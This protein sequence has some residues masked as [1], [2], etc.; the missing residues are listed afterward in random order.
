VKW[1]KRKAPH[2]L[3][4]LSGQRRFPFPLVQSG[5]TVM[6]QILAK[7]TFK[8]PMVPIIAKRYGQL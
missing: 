2:A 3:I 6:T 5:S 1:P 8:D 7:V 4:P